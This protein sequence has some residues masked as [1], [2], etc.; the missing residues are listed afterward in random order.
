MLSLI[1]FAQIFI[2]ISWITACSSFIASPPAN[3]TQTSLPVATSTLTPILFINHPKPGLSIVFDDFKDVGCPLEQYGEGL[4]NS[5]SPLFAL[6]C[7]LIRKP[8][9]LLGGLNPAYPIATCIVHPY[10]LNPDRPGEI[11]N[12]MMAEGEYFYTEGYFPV[13]FI[14]YVIVRDNQF[15]LIKTEAELREIYA[16]IET[17]EEA[18]SYVLTAKDLSAYYDLKRNPDYEYQSEVIED[19]YVKP[20]ENGY[21]LHMFQREVVG[22]G[23]HWTWGIEVHITS[24]GIIRE[25]SREKVFK[26]PA[27][28]NIC[29]D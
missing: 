13:D 18:L 17:S 23:P 2:Y 9:N 24:E 16:P 25:I 8:S 22:C 15:Q 5:N 29:Y 27:E 20:V 4:C 6:G 7:P 10:Y 21:H 1:R 26:D 12:K 14:R 3:P 28:D 19:T 11:Y